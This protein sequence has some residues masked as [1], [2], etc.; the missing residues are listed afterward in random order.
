MLH[1]FFNHL[2]VKMRSRCG[3]VFFIS[4]EQH[5]FSRPSYRETTLYDFTCKVGIY[6]SLVLLEIELNQKQNP[7][8]CSQSVIILMCFSF[9]FHF[10]ITNFNIGCSGTLQLLSHLAQHPATADM[11][12]QLEALCRRAPIPVYSAHNPSGFNVIQNVFA[13]VFYDHLKKQKQC[14]KKKNPLLMSAR[15]TVAGLLWFQGSQGPVD[16]GRIT[17]ARGR[18]SQ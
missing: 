13:T 8:D 14:L 11:H 1:F 17:T 15:R 6:F 12:K 9:S 10:C 2:R 5:F 18:C 4:T 16:A 3:L 7:A